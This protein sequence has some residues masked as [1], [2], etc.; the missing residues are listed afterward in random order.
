MTGCIGFFVVNRV[1]EQT[2]VVLCPVFFSSIDVNVDDM[3]R[4]IN[5]QLMPATITG[6]QI[7]P[8]K[9]IDRVILVIIMRD[10]DVIVIVVKRLMIGIDVTEVPPAVLVDLFSLGKEPVVG[11][12]SS[13]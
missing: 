3:S 9:S 4:Q 5:Q 10:K 6:K 2:V 12:M 7:L 8:R 1:P 11:I 13:A